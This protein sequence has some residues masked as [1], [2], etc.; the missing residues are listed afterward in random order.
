MVV[1]GTEITP[2]LP[3][4]VHPIFSKR[5]SITALFSTA[6]VACVT[7]RTASGEYA[8]VLENTYLGQC[9]QLEGLSSAVSLAGGSEHVAFAFPE[10]TVH[11]SLTLRMN[12]CENVHFEQGKPQKKVIKMAEQTQQHDDKNNTRSSV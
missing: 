7:N 3:A 4:S 1:A 12:S 10:S 9:G 6:V 2:P 8:R 11:N 5:R